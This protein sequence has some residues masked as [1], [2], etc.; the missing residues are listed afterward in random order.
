MHVDHA[1]MVKMWCLYPGV[2]LATRLHT[3]PKDLRATAKTKEFLHN[4]HT[5]EYKVT[6]S[7]SILIFFFYGAQAVQLKLSVVP[8]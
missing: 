6:H 3:T 5:L 7:P 4:N 2:D 1:V 8:L